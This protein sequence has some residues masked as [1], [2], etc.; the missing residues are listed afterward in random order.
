MAANGTEVEARIPPP[1]FASQKEGE[2]IILQRGNDVFYNKAQVVNRDLSISVLRTFV[3]ARREERS[4]APKGKRGRDKDKGKGRG[5]EEDGSVRTGTNAEDKNAG[6]DTKA[7]E[8]PGPE[9]DA[10]SADVKAV[11]TDVVA[12]GH[13]GLLSAEP[14]SANDVEANSTDPSPPKPLRVL[15]AL[16]ASGLRS[17]RYAI[18][19]EGIDSVVA[20]DNDPVAVE[21]CKRNVEFN[22]P[23]AAKV[24]P[25][26]ADARVYMLLHEKEFD[27]VD[28]DP[29]GSPCTFLDSAVQSVADGGLLMCTATD[30]AVLCGNNGEVC[31]SKYG[32]YPMRA[33]Y[34]HEM[35]LRILLASIES[36]A[37]RYKRHIVPVLSI[38][39]DFYIRVFV[40]VYSSALAMKASPSKLS[41]V[42]QCIGCD[43]FHLQ[44][45][46]RIGAK[47]NAVR[48]MAGQG[49][50]VGQHCEECG[51]AF[52]LG[53]PMWSAPMHDAQWLSST[54]ASVRKNKHLYPA[55]NKI[56]GLLTAASEELMDV[57]LFVSLHGLSATLKCTPPSSLLFRSALANAGY[58]TSGCHANALALKTDAPMHVLWDIMRCWVKDHPVKPQSDDSPGFIIL[59]REPKLEA[60]FSRSS[61]AMSRAQAN[62]VPRFIPNPETHWGPKPKAGRRI[63]PK[64]GQSTGLTPSTV[65]GKE[66]E[67]DTP[68]AKRVRET[69]ESEKSIL[70][71]ETE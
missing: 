57:P 51:K 31:Y 36:H 49:P 3:E 45:V 35:A 47:G 26:I 67:G 32:G 61:E 15:E 7:S 9:T 43:S 56:H 60:N 29:Y 28:L 1:G 10:S 5:G 27:V 55:Y 6:E 16:A 70:A 25:E 34:C 30:M 17:L 68:P 59:K 71:K 48:Y 52:H 65:G 46:G 58:R 13:G 38:S 24:L 19:I 20:L 8:L 14:S 18:E 54:L 40:R 39:V 66:K 11:K 12:N 37:N 42:F 64:H 50:T 2:A 44:P 41:H 21:A 69:D 23:K 33:K 22:G 4:S 53:G 62:G 63:G